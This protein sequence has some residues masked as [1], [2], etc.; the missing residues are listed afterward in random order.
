MI[1]MNAEEPPRPKGLT[2]GSKAP[3]INTTDIC[4]NEINL[5]ELIKNYN[6]VMID[7]FRGNW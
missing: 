6:G 3:M 5:S 1:D 2:I 7:F 4:D